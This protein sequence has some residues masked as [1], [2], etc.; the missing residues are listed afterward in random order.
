[1][2]GPIDNAAIFAGLTHNHTKKERRAIAFKATLIA[3]IVLIFF[4]ILG[5]KILFYIDVE[6]YA[7]QLGGGILLLIL[8]I[9]VVMNDY[10]SSENLALEHKHAKDFSVFPLAIPLIAG[11]GAI[12]QSL[13]LFGKAN[14]DIIK[15]GSVLACIAILMV[16][17]YVMFLFASHISRILGEK[18]AETLARILGI[19]L[20]ALAMNIIVDGF[21][22]SGLFSSI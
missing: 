19:F 13:I 12:T 14:G 9:Q 15:Q 21:K 17:S 8:G 6:F 4:P 10:E 1:M 3:G 5:D 22:A 2:V 11:P 18:G 7:L 16:V 20:T